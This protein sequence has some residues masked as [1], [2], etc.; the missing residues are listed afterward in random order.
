MSP[1]SGEAVG[2]EAAQYLYVNQGTNADGS[3]NYY[4][5]IYDS[6]PNGDSRSFEQINEVASEFGAV[7]R[8]TQVAPVRE[9][10]RTEHRG[11]GNY[12]MNHPRGNNQPSRIDRQKSKKEREQYWKN[13]ARELENK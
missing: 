6:G 10:T 4:V 13:K 12:G 5:G 8:D 2:A 11:K 9:M 1:K 3:A 7:I